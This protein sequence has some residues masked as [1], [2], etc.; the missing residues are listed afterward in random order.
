MDPVFERVARD[1]DAVKA[2][3]VPLEETRDG[4]VT[5]WTAERLHTWSNRPWNKDGRQLPLVHHASVGVE[6]TFRDFSAL[7]Q[8]IGEHIATIDGFR[9]ERIGWSLISTRREE[10]LK[11]A[12]TQAVGDAVTR[13]RQYADALGLGSIRPVAIADAGML[14]VELRPQDGAGSA[15]LR[16]GAASAAGP[17]V[18]FAPEDIEISAK[19]DARFAVDS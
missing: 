12:R 17:A 4:P 10:L 14:G 19:V 8:W 3:I 13:A 1:L 6:A 5:S 16:V 7:S 2:S 18:E 15:Y 9:V 11:H